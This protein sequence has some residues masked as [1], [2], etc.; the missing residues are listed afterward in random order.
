MATTSGFDVR[1]G[2]CPSLALNANP[3]LAGITASSTTTLVISTG[4]GTASNGATPGSGVAGGMAI[5]ASNASLPAAPRS[6]GLGTTISLTTCNPTNSACTATAAD[7]TGVASSD[8]AFT[9]CITSGFNCYIPSTGTF[10]IACADH[11]ATAGTILY[12]DTNKTS[13][14]QIVS[15]CALT[16]QTSGIVHN[17]GG[18]HDITIDVNNATKSSGSVESILGAQLGATNP[19]FQRVRVIN[20]TTRML[21]LA[22]TTG[23]S[24]VTNPVIDHSYFALTAAD[25]NQNDAILFSTSGG[26]SIIGGSITDNI[27]VNTG[28]E[29]NATKLTIV[30]NDISGWNFGSGITTDSSATS[31]YYKIADNYLHDSG[32]NQ[33]VNS[34]SAH[35][36]ELWGDHSN[37]TG[38]HCQNL[39]GRCVSIDS[40]HNQIVGNYAY[41]IGKV[42][43]GNVYAAFDASTASLTDNTVTGN[44]AFDD[45]GALASS[46]LTA[47]SFVVGS[48]YT[49]ATVGTTSFTSIGASANTVGI[50]FT[51][52]GAG[53]GTGT[54]YI[55]GTSYGYGEVNSTLSNNA[56]LANNF[57][58]TALAALNIKSTT[59]N[60]DWASAGSPAN[61]NQYTTPGTYTYTPPSGLKYVLVKA[62]GP[63][64]PGGSGAVQNTTTASSGGAAG[65][66][67]LCTASGGIVLTPSDI[68]AHLTI[69]VPST[70]SG[71]PATT[72]AVGTPTSG[73]AGV[74]GSALT[75]ANGSGLV[76]FNG[77]AGGG[78]SGGI[79]AATAAGSGGGAG[80]TSAGG[81]GSSG[82]GGSAGGVCGTGGSNGGGAVNNDNGGSCGAA[83]GGS[84][85]A[86][87]AQGGGHST[88]GGGAGGGAGGGTTS[89]GGANNGGTS[90]V[91][92]PQG[93]QSSGGTSGTPG[94][95]SG[96]ASRSSS[97]GPG[98][99]GGGGWGGDTTTA[100]AGTG[101]AG[102]YGSGG[103]G[104]GS[105]THSSGTITSGAGGNG[106][107][108]FACVIAVF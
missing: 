37:V 100:T 18:A 43:T 41:G 42:T 16:T 6:L 57:S 62:C 87:V 8:A 91:A 25:T 45:F 13:T 107:P 89:S 27:L 75:V 92:Y 24:N 28:I 20:A 97:C 66:G 4:N 70:P 104:G 78:G 71:A 80:F 67:G 2:A 74:G 72:A 56:I 60:I 81:N 101:G 40:S 86:G 38:N 46:A 36:I 26:G 14:L 93:A 29:V 85:A 10:Q 15:G 35:G 47:G 17:L 95:G 19:A 11:A 68:G 54:A 98:S 88:D 3:Y 65:S 32:F 58:N 82:S 108:A 51:A 90:G 12:G 61:V 103:G 33:D 63:G 48:S 1:P 52:T 64:G 73:T 76:L 83:G 21:L 49:I 44:R 7:P 79:A 53:S 77:Y 102:G 96:L 105:T 99:G 94:G 9:A 106:G 69:V 30:R 23:G 84:T 31:N 22:I 55:N 50:V 34:T 39:G 5:D 59:D